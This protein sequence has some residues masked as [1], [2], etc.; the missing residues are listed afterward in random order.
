MVNS[1][2]S[3]ESPSEDQTG[4]VDSDKLNVENVKVYYKKPGSSSKG[5]NKGKRK[6]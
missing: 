1:K 5:G 4:I 3:I 6:K 2:K